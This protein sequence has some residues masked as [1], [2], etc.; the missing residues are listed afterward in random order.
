MAIKTKRKVQHLQIE[1]GELVIKRKALETAV[2]TLLTNADKKATSAE[3]IEELAK[4]I[5][6]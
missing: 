3:K 1:I 5:K 6:Y 4:K 2:T